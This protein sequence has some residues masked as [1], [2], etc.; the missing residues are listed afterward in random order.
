MQFL[1]TDW[2]TG[3]RSP[4]EAKDLSSSLCIQT[5][6]EARPASYPKDTGVPFPGASARPERDADHIPI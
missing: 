4:A 1:T 2:T 5:S 3:V 6:S